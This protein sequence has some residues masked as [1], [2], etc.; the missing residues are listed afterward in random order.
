[1]TQ[2]PIQVHTLLDL[3][4]RRAR[5]SGVF[6]EV[7]VFPTRVECAA[8]DS[9]EPACYRVDVQAG[10]VLVSLV[11][12]NRWLSE[13][14]E[15]DLLHTGDSMEELVEEELVELGIS[16]VTPTV[17]HFRSEDR[18]FTFMSSV[19]GGLG[20]GADTIATWLLAYEAAFRNLG[21]MQGG[22]E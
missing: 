14:I 10:D 3:V 4:A 7:V 19:P 15:T 20:A 17:R 9:A 22:D 6:G 8:R 16:G 12:A 13:S 5:L 11:T 18:M 1:M 21:D 2:A